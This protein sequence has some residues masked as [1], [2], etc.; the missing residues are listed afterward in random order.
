MDEPRIKEISWEQL[1][2]LFE[3]R[4]FAIPEFQREF[5][6]N[7]KKIAAL[8]DS[9]LKKYPI[10]SFLIC[11][12]P[13]KMHGRIRQHTALPR[14]NDQNEECW[15]V[16]DGQQRLCVLYNVFDGRE[17]KS[18]RSVNPIKTANLYFSPRGEEYKFGFYEKPQKYPRLYDVLTCKDSNHLSDGAK[19]FV[20][21]LEKFRFPFMFL[22]NY[23]ED[24][25]K[26][27][28]NRLNLKGTPLSTE[29]QLFSLAS[30]KN[31][32]LRHDMEQTYHDLGRI[33]PDLNQ[34]DSRHILNAIIA[35]L[36]VDDVSKS[37]LR[38]TAKKLSK[39]KSPEHREYSKKKSDI[40]ESI[41]KSAHFFFGENAFHLP[42]TRYLPYPAMISVLA[43]FYHENNNRGP[44]KI[45]KQEIEKWFWLTGLFKRYSGQKYA[46][47][48]KNDI[49]QMRKLAKKV[50][51]RLDVNETD[52]SVNLSVLKTKDYSRQ[53][54]L[55]STIFA[56]IVRSNPPKFRP[57]KFSDPEEYVNLTLTPTQSEVENLH[58]IF[59]KDFL[60]TYC[61]NK[62]K[63][64]RN[65]V[66][67]I[68]P[69]GFEDN[70]KHIGVK[71]PWR[72]F[73]EFKERKKG[74]YN[75]QKIIKSH[76]IPKEDCLYNKPYNPEKAYKKFL[77]ARIKLFEAELSK[78]VGK[79][80]FSKD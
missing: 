35:M 3:D 66:A 16:I 65:S 29:D 26:E 34:L 46:R 10:G 51:Y 55:T 32:D 15:L 9:I 7:K 44:T 80:Y 23:D 49:K 11:K 70:A 27:A 13:S 53:D 28:F 14:F 77:D 30:G 42:R 43:V 68:T 4:V 5:V 73:K 58:H 75:L 40:F 20:N 17:L 63:S 78:R 47:C 69:I 72:Y 1:K 12:I 79:K 22:S 21:T 38:S 61:S 60:K 31:I 8:F 67:N 41:K 48:I 62:I 50:K 64:L 36:G 76:L 59:P 19:T 6:W 45:Q 24:Y 18:E 71:P 56:L 52:E 37:N 57:Y 33:N 74:R 39:P 25:L 2:Q 54:A